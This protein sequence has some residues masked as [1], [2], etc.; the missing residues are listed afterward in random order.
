MFYLIVSFNNLQYN[1]FAM[2][3][4]ECKYWVGKLLYE[5]KTGI[6]KVSFESLNSLNFERVSVILIDMAHYI[7]LNK[8]NSNILYTHCKTSTNGVALFAGKPLKICSTL[9]NTI[10]FKPDS[11]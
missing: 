11:T 7:S 5:P 1:V 9:K 10:Y 8:H 6:L 4:I 2:L 3:N